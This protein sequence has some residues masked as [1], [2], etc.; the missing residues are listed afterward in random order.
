MAHTNFNGHTLG[1]R[2]SLDTLVIKYFF[3]IHANEN[4]VWYANFI[5]ERHINFWIKCHEFS[6][7]QSNEHT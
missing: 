3:G 7:E 4:D 1:V 6:N 5:D 2:E